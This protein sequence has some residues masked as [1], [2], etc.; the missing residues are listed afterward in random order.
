MYQYTVARSMGMS[1][2]PNKYHALKMVMHTGH[3]INVCCGFT[4]VNASS[5]LDFYEN[6]CIDCQFLHTVLSNKFYVESILLDEY[7]PILDKRQWLRPCCELMLLFAALRNWF[8]KN[9][10]CKSC[11]H[12]VSNWEDY[13]LLRLRGCDMTFGLLNYNSFEYYFREAMDIG[14]VQTVR[15]WGDSE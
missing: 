7:L 1:S 14:Y 9:V 4:L 3:Y 2:K 12:I 11:L 8:G 5:V 13:F 15:Q 10:V 6:K